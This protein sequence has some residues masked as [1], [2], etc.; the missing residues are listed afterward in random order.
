M[1]GVIYCSLTMSQMVPGGCKHSW[2]HL[3]HVANDV[4]ENVNVLDLSILFLY[5]LFA[6]VV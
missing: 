2:H 5:L 6:V 4:M 1:S 3:L